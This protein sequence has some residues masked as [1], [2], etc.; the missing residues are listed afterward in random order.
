[1]RRNTTAK[2]MRQREL[3]RAR[4]HRKRK[5]ELRAAQLKRLL[6]RLRQRELPLR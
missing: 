6:D 3:Q 1:M 4:D 5:R 2:A